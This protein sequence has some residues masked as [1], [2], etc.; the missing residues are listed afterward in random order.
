[1][2]IFLLGFMGSGKSTIGKKLA[3]K[4][5]LKFVDL[6]GFIEAE[7][8]CSVEDAF[9]LQGEKYF[10]EQEEKALIKMSKQDDFV[11]ALGGGAPCFASNFS[12]IKSTG[13]SVYL[14]M[15]KVDLYNRLA[16]NRGN[17]PLLYSLN[18]NELEAYISS[19]LDVREEYYNQA[20]I[21]ISAKDFNAERYGMLI[22]EIS[23][24]DK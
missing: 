12:L 18:E 23:T 21:V 3:S 20:D 14:Q 19:S 1:M 24:Y 22:E 2:R 7:M 4:M 11:V 16:A 9:A 6:D 5:N 15:E 8:N 17:R 13:I 10:R